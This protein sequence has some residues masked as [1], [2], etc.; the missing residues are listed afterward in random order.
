MGGKKS[1]KK[2]S[3]RPADDEEQEP[4]PIERGEAEF[5]NAA[6]VNADDEVVSADEEDPPVDDDDDEDAVPAPI[7]EPDLFGEAE[8]AFTEDGLAVATA[9]DAAGE[10]DYIY[11]AIEY[12]PD[13]KPPLHKNQ[14][15][16]V[17]TC[18]A[19]VV[20]VSV[21]TVVVVF[22][23]KSAKAADITDVEVL[24]NGDPS[25]SP[26]APPTT[27]REAS[28][29]REQVEAGILQRGANFTDMD[30]ADPRYRAL[31]WILHY[32]QQ[33]LD[34]DDVRLYQRYVLA[35]L[36]FQLD[37]LA[38]K[39]C[40][41]HRIFGNVT[42]RFANENCAVVDV[43]GTGRT[44]AHHVWLSSADE[45]GWYGVVCSSDDVVRGL[46]LMGNQVIGEIP[47]EISQLRFL[48]YLALNGNCLYGTIPPEFGQMHNLLSLELH[49]NG[50]SGEFPVELYDAS[51]LQ[52][53]N[54]AMQYLYPHGQCQ[55][56]NGTFVSTLYERGGVSSDQYNHGLWGQVLTPNASR[57]ESMKGL[58]L[59]DNS[60]SGVIAEEI[61]ELKYLV[62]LK[63]QNNDFSGYL[64]NGLAKLKRLRELH[65]QENSHYGDLLPD[66][67]YME[68][69]QDLRLG[70]NMMFGPIPDSLYKLSKL[71]M[72]WLQDTLFCTEDWECRVTKDEGFSGTLSTEI[73]N[74]KKLSYLILNA[75]PFEGS[76]P[77]EIGL[78]EKLSILHVH[79]TNFD[80]RSPRELCELRDKELHGQGGVFY[81]D[82][83]PNNSTQDP[84][85]RCDCCT[86][87]CDHT[88][89]VCIADD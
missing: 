41:E 59:F 26:T 19:F 88:T 71:K 17:Y 73:G 2:K 50:L 43:Y 44:E 9:I 21:I 58:H 87:C 49:G 11:A 20:V 10:D 24:V 69:L 77:T 67:G 84:F 33:Q 52:L 78:C 48:S 62:Y 53:L 80:G 34:S 70:G 40:G 86:D 1:K 8:P 51:K 4:L 76:I 54:V 89:Q 83:R 22:V 72:L 60:F 85:F 47:P 56:S 66:I 79:K 13:S 38:W 14:R 25:A 68:D 16:R 39:D 35:L 5:A 46:E 28:G 23:S 15:F 27:D 61:G 81:S 65:L 3:R 36:G 57:W 37:S 29:I 7:A 82:C 42:E 32:D 12:D 18:L 45:C 63:A 75:N 74:L 64:P 30:E 6:A 55:M 31:D